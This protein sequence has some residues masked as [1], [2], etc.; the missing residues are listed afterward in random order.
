MI[1]TPMVYQGF[2]NKVAILPKRE[3]KVDLA[4]KPPW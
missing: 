4:E 3:L 1:K 2:D